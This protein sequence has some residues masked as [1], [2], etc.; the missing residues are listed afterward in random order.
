[1]PDSSRRLLGSVASTPF[2]ARSRS[3]VQCAQKCAECQLCTREME[4]ALQ[5]HKKENMEF[6]FFLLFP[7][8]L[9]RKAIN[10]P[11]IMNLAGS[12]LFTRLYLFSYLSSTM[13][14]SDQAFLVNP[15]VPYPHM[16]LCMPGQDRVSSWCLSCLCRVRCEMQR[17]HLSCA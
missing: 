17:C 5:S 14:M 7:Q 4:N 9:F 2:S 12:P 6:S 16:W 15:S 8:T 10:G 3:Q 1:M 13:G 11:L